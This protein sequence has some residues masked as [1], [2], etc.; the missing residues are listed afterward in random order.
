LILLWAYVQIRYAVTFKALSYKN[1]IAR[2]IVVLKT[3]FLGADL[4]AIRCHA[5]TLLLSL[6]TSTAAINIH[7]FNTPLAMAKPK[8]LK[9]LRRHGV[10]ERER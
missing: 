1:G 6:Q 9:R 3:L 10:L 8:D 7:Q 4:G 2:V 5:S